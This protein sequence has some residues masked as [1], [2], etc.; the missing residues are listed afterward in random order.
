MATAKVLACALL[1]G[2]QKKDPSKTWEGVG[3]TIQVGS[4]TYR[5]I[6]FPERQSVNGGQ[7]LK[8]EA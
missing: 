1:S 7:A 4:I 2:K 3:V 8:V 6:I 5:G